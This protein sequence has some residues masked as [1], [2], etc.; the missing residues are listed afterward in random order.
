[1]KGLRDDILLGVPEG[2]VVRTPC[3]CCQGPGFDPEWGNLDPARHVALP[4][5]EKKERKISK[6]NKSKC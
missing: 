2:P 3:F 5:K 6:M 4:K 1:M